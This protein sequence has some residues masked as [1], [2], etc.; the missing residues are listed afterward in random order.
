[1]TEPALRGLFDHAGMFPPA[2][3]SLPDA[4]RDAA[5]FPRSLQRPGLVGAD[6]VVAWKDW[7]Q[8]DAKALAAAGFEGTRPCRIALV[9]VPLEQAAEAAAIAGAAPVA[10]LPIVSL[11]VHAEGDVDADRLRRTVAAA[12]GVPVYLEPRWPATRVHDHVGHVALVCKV[13]G[14]GLKVRCAGATALDR[15]ALAAAVVAA[16]DAGIPFKATQGLH[17]PVPR[18]GFPH[19]FLGLLAAVRLKQA[20]GPA[21]TDVAAC[22]AE[23]DVTNFGLADGIR[24]RGNSVPA[25]RLPRLPPFAIGSCSLAEPDEDLMAAFGPAPAR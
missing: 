21:F 8:L 17:H 24:W 10:R 22:L 3:K 2:A 11:E 1:M 25:E 23:T 5:A 15:P 18:P 6:M 14:A 12:R 19:G 20:H 4:L 13:A 16:A 9:G 7:V